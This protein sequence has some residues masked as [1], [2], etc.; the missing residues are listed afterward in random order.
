MKNTVIFGGTFNPPHLAHRQIL[1]SICGLEET[2][3]VIVMPTSIPPHK[4]CPDLACDAD[5]YEM[6]RLAFSGI[7]N[8]T[9]SDAEIR[10][11]GKSYTYDTVSAFKKIYPNE[12]LSIVCGG[13]MVV[14]F[15]QWYRYKEIIK[16]A[17]IIAVRRVGT[18]NAEFDSAV[19][20]LLNEGARIT[21]LKNTVCGISSTDIR[22]NINNKKY[23]LEYLDEKVYHYI[24]E[25]KL[26]TE[27]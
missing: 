9:V 23:L 22:K 13:D 10:R 16:T 14:S 21:V 20:G 25:N 19:S 8:V 4:I 15:T 24:I 26:Y 3:K 11:A 6:C 7:E 1:E 27:E 2:S 17:D 12:P 5:R 18:D